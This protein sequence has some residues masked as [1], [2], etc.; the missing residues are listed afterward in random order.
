VGSCRVS[1]GSENGAGSFEEFW[2][3]IDLSEEPDGESCA[4]CESFH[5]FI[6]A[7]RCVGVCD[8][9]V[10]IEHALNNP[11]CCFSEPIFEE[12]WHA[13]DH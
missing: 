3:E 6:P 4:I 1:V 8:V 7:T 11:D 13:C 5:F 2:K 10:E 9:V 12:F